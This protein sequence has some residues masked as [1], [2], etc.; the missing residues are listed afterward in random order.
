MIFDFT[1]RSNTYNKELYTGDYFSKT[2]CPKCS[3]IG[4]FKLH[5]S[6][7]RFIIYFNKK[8]LKHKFIEIKRVRCKSCKSTHAVMPSDLIPYRMLSFYVFLYILTVCFVEKNSVI[9]TA[10]TLMFS[11]QFIYSCIYAFKLHKSRIHQYFMETMYPDSPAST[12]VH[13]IISLIKKPYIK[14]QFGYTKLNLRPCFMCK[15]FDRPGAPPIGLAA[16]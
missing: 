16:P 13:D 4:R 1:Q 12:S 10:E 6:Y 11:F 14:F 3:A 2:P 15:F 7:K 8:K 5:G 9:E